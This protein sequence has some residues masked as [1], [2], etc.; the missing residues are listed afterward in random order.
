[1][2][3]QTVRMRDF[4]MVRSGDKGNTV[5]ISLFAPTPELYAV[6]VEQ[7]TPERVLEHFRPMARGPVERYMIP[8]LRALKFVIKDALAGG[9]ASSLRS[10]NLGKVYGSNLLRLTVT[11]DTA[12]LAA[13]P[14]MRH[15]DSRHPGPE[16]ADSP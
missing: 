9:A 7:L 5:D 10:D 8:N 4:C 15:P 16:P 14:G 2:S 1:M 13:A 3:R 11:L 12:L 6:L